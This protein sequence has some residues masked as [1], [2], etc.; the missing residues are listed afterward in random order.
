VAVLAIGRIPDSH[1]K[2]EAI[3]TAIHEVLGT[4]P[5]DWFVR[6]SPSVASWTLSVRRVSDGF[7][8]TLLLGPDQLTAERV[9]SEL[10]QALTDA[11]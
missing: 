3:E 1:P 8:R 7:R 5:G 4:V 11:A 6:V 10:Q 9:A 2:R